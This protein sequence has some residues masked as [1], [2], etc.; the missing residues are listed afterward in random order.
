MIVTLAL[1]LACV[2]T[3]VRTR[4]IPNGLS[5][6]G[7][8]AGFALNAAYHGVPGVTAS[9]V[10]ALVMISVLFAP[11]ALGGIGAGDV[12]MMAAVAALLG[13]RL[14]FAALLVGMLFGGIIMIGHLARV[15]RLREKLVSTGQMFMLAFGARSMEPLRVSAAQPGA[16]ALPYSVPL[17]LGTAAVALG[18][19]TAPGFLA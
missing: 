16:V 1:V 15:G 14:G 10:A 18:A 11:F 9:L 4:R 7:L 5:L 6:T 3:D 2:L 19:L 13:L 12:K 17:A 8:I